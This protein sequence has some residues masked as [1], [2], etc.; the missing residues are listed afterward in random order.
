MYQPIVSC[1]HICTK[2]EI[3]TSIN[4]NNIKCWVKI[5]HWRTIGYFSCRPVLSCHGDTDTAPVLI[6]CNHRH[7][8]DKY[9]IKQLR[10]RCHRPLPKRVSTRWWTA[11]VIISL[12]L[13][14]WW[15]AGVVICL[16][17]G[18]D[19]HMAQL[20]PLPLTVS[21][22]SEIQIGFYLSGT[23]SPG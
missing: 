10:R 22:F 4:E 6:G 8:I 2:V 1:W 18:A 7:R 15:G 11:Q 12:F 13:P 14:E 23:S 9:L 16:E 5:F 17:W 3:A 19:L 21:C 20:M